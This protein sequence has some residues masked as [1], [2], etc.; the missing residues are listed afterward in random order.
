MPTAPGYY[1]QKFKE[2]KA[3]WGN[4]CNMVDCNNTHGLEFAHVAPT[5]L[6]GRGRGQSV[7]Y[8]DIKKH[9]ERY[10]LIC[11]SCHVDI[12]FGGDDPWEN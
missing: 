9:P 7:R 3:A 5:P 1:A 4:V 12:D 10:L 6:N 2:L 11:R 8:Y